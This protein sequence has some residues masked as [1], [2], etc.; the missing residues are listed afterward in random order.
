MLL[1]KNLE[2]YTG[3]TLKVD[4]KDTELN[5]LVQAMVSATIKGANAIEFGKLLDKLQKAF[6]KE[7]AKQNG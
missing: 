5:I 7:V 2:K 1:F 4:L 6:E 3:G